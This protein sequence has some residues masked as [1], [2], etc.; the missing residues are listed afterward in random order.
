MTVL[1]PERRPFH[2][3]RV[4][5]RSTENERAAFHVRA[6]RFALSFGRRLAAHNAFDAAS[7]V[8]FWFFLSF[9]PLLVMVG[10][11]LGQVARSRGVDSLVGPALAI[12][13]GGGA[14]RL[15]RMELERLATTN[16]ASLAPVGVVGYFWTATSGLQ[17]L[18]DV[19]EI[20]AKVERR[21]W[22]KKRCIALAWVVVGLGVMCLLG[23][24]LVRVQSVVDVLHTRLGQVLVGVL[25]LAVGMVL[26]AVFYRFAVAHPRGARGRVWPGT[27]TAVG[28][29]LLVSY[30]F[31]AYV[32]SIGSYTLYYGSL[33]AVTVLLVWLYL[34]S[35]SL[36]VGAEVNLALPS[37]TGRWGKP[38]EV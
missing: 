3:R 29:W 25:M 1:H 30:G 24:L 38:S 20:A 21:S 11:L 12:V 8:A 7:S 6:Y 15:V 27:V 4:A 5:T 31:G 23:W 34:T 10:F 14:D 13:P 19:F 28:L 36:V 32:V 37:T 26:L 17:N 2:A 33:A 22:W 18:M 9:I 16:V 35:L